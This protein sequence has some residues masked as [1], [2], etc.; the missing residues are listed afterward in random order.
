[1]M[2]SRTKA[3]QLAGLVVWLTITFIAAAVGALASVQANTFYAE[4]LKPAWA[5]PASLFGPVWST[6]YTLIA[7]AAWL[8]WRQGGFA[9]RRAALLLF[10]GQLALNALW[11]WLF[12]VWHKGALAL[13]DI[14]ALWLLIVATLIAFWRVKALA[15]ALFLPYLL[16][17]SFAAVLNYSLWQLN[18]QL[19]G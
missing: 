9:A 7:I 8:V 16:W 3:Q 15:G 4:L 10:L 12:F 11:S 17:V 1:M 13:V 5:P 19:L 14:I 6:L 18:P 2:V